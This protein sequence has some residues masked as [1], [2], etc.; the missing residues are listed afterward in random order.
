MT[1]ILAFLRKQ[2]A[3]GDQAVFDPEVVHAMSVAFDEVCRALGVNDDDKARETIAVRIIELARRGESNADRLRDRVI[4]EANGGGSV[5]E[6]REPA[7]KWGRL[8]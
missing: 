6:L 4:R 3:R 2:L 1:A 7:Q 8:A 5:D